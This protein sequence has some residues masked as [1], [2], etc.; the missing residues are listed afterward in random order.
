MT[1]KLEWQKIPICVFRWQSY[2]Q[3]YDTHLI[4]FH[5]LIW[6]WECLIPCVFLLFWCAVCELEIRFVSL[7]AGGVNV[8]R[9]PAERGS[10]ARHTSDNDAFPFF[11]STETS[12][13]R[14]C[15]RVPRHDWSREILPSHV[16]RNTQA[17]D[18]IQQSRKIVN[19]WSFLPDDDTQTFLL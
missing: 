18:V 1:C 19:F 10:R 12:V 7:V 15:S 6:I 8:A 2:W 17:C 16:H 14:R 5:R 11:I 3:R 9:D 4:Y 13:K